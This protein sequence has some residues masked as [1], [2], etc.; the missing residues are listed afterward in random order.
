MKNILSPNNCL[1]IVLVLFSSCNKESSNNPID[2]VDACPP[3]S[4]SEMWTCHHLSSWDMITTRDALIGE[5]VWK[6]EGCFWVPEDAGCDGLDAFTI[7]FKNDNTLVAKE[8]GTI[9]QT[10]TWKVIEGDADL[11][12]IEA[13]PA[14]TTLYGRILFCDDFVEFNHSYIDGCDNYF[15]R[16]K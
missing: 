8:N 15:K 1:I 13:T 3:K 9:I 14:V 16:K 4:Q 6:Y 2:Q 11:Y 10:A 5:W 7:E 12:S